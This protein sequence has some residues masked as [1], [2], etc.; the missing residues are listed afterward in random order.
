MSKPDYEFEVF[1]I[2]QEVRGAEKSIN[3]GV[4]AILDL[5]EETCNK[6]I[7]DN[8]PVSN[9]TTGGD[10]P[11]YVFITS[12]NRMKFVQRKRLKALMGGK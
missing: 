1:Y 6:V 3:E 8:E 4:E 10:K 7:G 9:K 2:L 12:R 5:I 11:N